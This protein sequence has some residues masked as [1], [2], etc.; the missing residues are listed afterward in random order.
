MTGNQPEFLSRT[1]RLK[2]IECICNQ[3]DVMHTCCCNNQRQ[4][5][6]VDI[7]KQAA[8]YALSVFCRRQR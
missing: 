5:K 3:F 2:S 8:F 1:P 7:C 4:G 6:P